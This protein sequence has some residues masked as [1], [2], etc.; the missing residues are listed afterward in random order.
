MCSADRFP[1]VS[2]GSLGTLA[3]TPGQ[4]KTRYL[5]GLPLLERSWPHIYGNRVHDAQ[6]D[7]D[8]FAARAFPQ[9]DCAGARLTRIG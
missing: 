9:R 6:D 8:H 4:P 2:S 5:D 1:A 3:S 7:R